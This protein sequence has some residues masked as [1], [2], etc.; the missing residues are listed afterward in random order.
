MKSFETTRRAFVAAAG[1]AATAPVLP[2]ISA[3]A[4]EC[5][6]PAKTP[7]AI[8]WER[9]EALNADLGAFADEIAPLTGRAGLPGWMHMAGDANRIGHER[10]DALIGI[11]KTKARSLDDLATMSRVLNE[12]E[13]AHGP[14]TWARFQ[15]DEAA[16][17][18][19]LA[20]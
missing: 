20:A 4:G 15:F 14:A 18:F 16:R 19:H 12:A 3:L 7:V 5:P 10:Y 13:I 2:V 11:L 8:L 6:A 1:A 9:A 17:D